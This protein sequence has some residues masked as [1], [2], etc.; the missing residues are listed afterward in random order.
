MGQKVALFSLHGVRPGTPFSLVPLHVRCLVQT[1]AEI[2]PPKVV[3]EP[4]ALLKIG[5]RKFRNCRVPPQTRE[6]E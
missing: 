1:K 2:T 4:E 3:R 6:T 5:G